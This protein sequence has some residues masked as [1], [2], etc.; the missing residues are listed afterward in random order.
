MSFFN[1][2]FI[3]GDRYYFF[4]IRG[5]PLIDEKKGWLSERN[6]T[7]NWIFYQGNKPTNCKW[8]ASSLKRFVL[9]G[10]GKGWIFNSIT[11]GGR[12]FI[13]AEGAGV[14][15]VNR[16]KSRGS[17]SALKFYGPSN[18]VLWIWSWE[19]L[20]FPP[21][22]LKERGWRGYVKFRLR[23]NTG[24]APPLSKKLMAWIGAL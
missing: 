2:K 7:S 11:G 24:P 1:R 13:E 21:Y 19:I 3:L 10:K 5:T 16:M 17:H 20:D 15:S 9:F 8:D 4:H 18:L 6:Y 22:S 23:I 12:R 14:L